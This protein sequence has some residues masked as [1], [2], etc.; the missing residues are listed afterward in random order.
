ME[1][2]I[3][4]GVQMGYRTVLTLSG[5]TS[6]EDLA[7]FAYRPDMVVNSVADLTD[8]AFLL[9]DHYEPALVGSGVD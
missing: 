4:G 9:A 7:Q 5:G 3:L 6:R 8:P 1:T 2:D